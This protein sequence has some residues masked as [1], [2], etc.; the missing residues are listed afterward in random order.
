MPWGLAIWAVLPTTALCS[1]GVARNSLMT[2]F[3]FMGVLPS[4]CTV[5]HLQSRQNIIV[6]GIVNLYLQ[7]TGAFES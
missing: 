2:W 1:S 7:R 3:T 6:E 4:L 5:T